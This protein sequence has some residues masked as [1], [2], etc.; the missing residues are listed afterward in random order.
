MKGGK[1][2]GCPIS[3]G[4]VVWLY[5]TYYLFCFVACISP[6]QGKPAVNRRFV[7]MCMNV[8]ILDFRVS[9]ESESSVILEH[10]GSS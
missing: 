10:I 2:K 6:N 5:A 8:D 4:S 1:T 9:P 3:P 7:G